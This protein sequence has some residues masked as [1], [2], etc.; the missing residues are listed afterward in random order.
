VGVEALLAQSS[1]ERLHER[2][3]DR[4]AWPAEV[5]RHAMLVGPAIERVRHELRAVVD[6][7]PLGRA[8]H[9]NDG[10]ERIGDLLAG[11]ALVHH[12]GQR[13]AREHIEQRQRAQAPAVEQRVRHEVHRP[14]LVRHRRLDAFDAVRR[15]DVA[16]RA[17]DPQIQAFL[18]IQP[19]HALVVHDEAL[20]T[21]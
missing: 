11:D 17:F 1:V 21:Q 9:G 16:V 19:P 14:D 18:A 3:V 10:I 20:P 15:A 6:P 13:L 8:A 4:L 12:D 5:E 7:D 2:V